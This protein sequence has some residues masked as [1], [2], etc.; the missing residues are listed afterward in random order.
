MDAVHRVVDFH[1]GRLDRRF[2]VGFDG[3][4]A[5]RRLAAGRGRNRRLAHGDGG[6]RSIAHSCDR[7]IRTGPGDRLVRC[8][9]R[10]D[11][12]AQKAGFAKVNRQG[13]RADGNPGNRNGR[14]AAGS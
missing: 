6:H 7:C 9:R 12:R 1:Q 11:L 4:E 5:G 3:H 8:I 2:P 13:G 14:V 10:A